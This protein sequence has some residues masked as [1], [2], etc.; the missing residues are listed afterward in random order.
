MTSANV[1]V[2][3]SMLKEEIL[4][5]WRRNETGE[6]VDIGV[7]DKFLEALNAGEVR[8]AEEKNGEWITNEWVKKG[9][10]L[11]FSVRENRKLVYGD[12]AYHDKFE[13]K[14]TSDF[15]EKGT[16]NT[17]DGTVVRDG[18][19]IGDSV[20][21]MSPS[22]VNVG[23]YVGDGT[24]V[25]SCDTIGSCAQ[26]GVLEP[27]EDSPVII[28]DGVSIG[29]GSKITSGFVV[30]EDSVIAENTLLNPSIPIFDFV[31]DEII[32]G[33][34]PP[35][36]RVMQRFVESSI[37]GFGENFYKP[38]AVATSLGDET[39]EKTRKEERLRQQ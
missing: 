12:V 16:R 3:V 39:L 22:F 27:V 5:A 37:E 20:I 21:M 31:E 36:R 18:A 30:G 7:L 6:S 38:A 14:D 15:L 29:G 35:R 32:Y 26:I 2:G 23:A 1:G 10:L 19:Y 28:E 9:I 34:I 13:L 25:D 4:E 17:P 11:N 8:A 33:R 24:L